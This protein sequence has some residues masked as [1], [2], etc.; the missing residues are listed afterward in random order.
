M[1]SQVIILSVC[2]LR[3]HPAIYEETEEVEE[4]HGMLN[5]YIELNGKWRYKDDPNYGDMM[6]RF[7]DGEPLPED[8]TALNKEAYGK[9]P[10]KP[11]Q[12]ATH[13][14]KDRDA[15]NC[16]IFEEY[17]KQNET[18]DG[19]AISGAIVVFMD[20]LEMQ[21]STKTWAEVKSNAV[22]KFLYTS[23]GEE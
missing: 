6:E 1:C 15:I 14:N 12:I 8:I 11:M 16:G 22:K 23:C 4:F 5:C 9:E 21:T 17:C 3:K 20:E 18:A 19:T 10:D 2:L 13:A 7:R